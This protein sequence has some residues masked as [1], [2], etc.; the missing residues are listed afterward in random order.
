[1]G[2]DLALSEMVEC[3]RCG[4][5]EKVVGRKLPGG[6]IPRVVLRCA[7][8]SRPK[9]RWSMVAD[10]PA[11]A[12]PHRFAIVPERSDDEPDEDSEQQKLF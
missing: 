4:V 10:C 2:G 12:V 6:W 11:C 5:Q 3:A 1:L 7:P 8:G 9:G